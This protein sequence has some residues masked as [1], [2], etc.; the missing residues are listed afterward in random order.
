MAQTTSA[1]M[2]VSFKCCHW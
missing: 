1:V 2:L